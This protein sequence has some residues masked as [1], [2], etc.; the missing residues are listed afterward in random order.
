MYNCKPCDSWLCLECI[1]EP[2]QEIMVCEKGH[3]MEFTKFPKRNWCKLCDNCD[4]NIRW[5]CNDPGCYRYKICTKCI[6]PIS[7]K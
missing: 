7:I 2:F 5:E 4:E 1:G 3:H 6:E